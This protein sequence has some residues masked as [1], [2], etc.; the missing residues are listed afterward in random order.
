MKP[1]ADPV[2]WP[3]DVRE[4]IPRVRSLLRTWNVEEER[5]Q[6]EGWDFYWAVNDK[7]AQRPCLDAG[8][9]SVYVVHDRD[10]KE[11]HGPFSVYWRYPAGCCQYCGHT[12]DGGW[13][14]PWC[15]SC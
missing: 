13:E 11:G 1:K 8:E 5:P 14:C 3:E 4:D 6:M 7:V 12:L 2:Y 15:G 10:Q 9:G